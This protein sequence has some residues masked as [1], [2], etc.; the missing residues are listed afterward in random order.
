M[1]GQ[2]V[3]GRTLPAHRQTCE[4]PGQTCKKL[5]GDDRSEWHAAAEAEAHRCTPASEWGKAV[6]F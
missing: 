3:E 5:V 6:S 4:A 1:T 2:S